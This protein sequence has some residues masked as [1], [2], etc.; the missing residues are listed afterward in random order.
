MLLNGTITRGSADP[1]TEQFDQISA[2]GADYPEAIAALDAAVPEGWQ[3]SDIR[4]A[5]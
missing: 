1:K 3:L 2:S 4:R 5:D